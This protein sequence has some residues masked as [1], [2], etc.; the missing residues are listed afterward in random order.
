MKWI[1]LSVEAHPEAVDAI[2]GVFQEHGTGGVA[3]EQPI[4]SHIEGE[5]PATF[6]GL[7]IIRAY[8][9]L[10]DAE[11][12]LESQ[13]EQALWHLQAFNLSPVGALQRRELD[14]EDWANGWKEHFHPLK[15][16]NVVIKPTW[17]QWDAAPD[18]VIVELDPGMAFGTGLHPTTQLMVAALQERV[19]PG[20]NVLD[21]GAG[22]GILAIAAGRFGTRVCGLDISDVA[23]E[24]ARANVA[25]NGLVDRITMDIGSIEQIEGR[26]FDLILANIIA[27]VLIELAPALYDTL[28]PRAE[29]LA[30]GIIEERVDLV[31]DAFT[32][33]GLETC[34][35]RRDGDWFLLAARRPA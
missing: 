15:I 33:A 26:Q 25:A 35:E 12:Q 28:A 23:V 29:V 11:A 2:A 13:I 9:P 22:S 3:I 14:E 30:S 17:R 8:L 19:K 34:E 20:M 5:E 10:N 16:G 32:A 1:E 18:E 6:E 21:L 4:R 27:S 7:P 31:R 24:V